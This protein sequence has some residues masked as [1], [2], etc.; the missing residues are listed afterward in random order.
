[1]EGWPIQ[2]PRLRPPPSS[3]PVV[4]TAP[5]HVPAVF[6]SRVLRLSATQLDT[7]E[8]CPLRYA[9]Q[10]AAG[11]RGDGSVSSELG[12][13]V[14]EVLAEFLSPAAS[15]ERD[16]AALQAVAEGHWRD[17]I[18][19]FRPQVEETRRAYFEMLDGWWDAEGSDAPDVLATEHEFEIAVG[20]HTVVGS[21]DRIDR[22]AGGVR[23]VDFKSGKREPAAKEMP[24]NLQLAVYHLAATRDPVIAAWGEPVA[25][26][27][28]F[29]RSMN[30]RSQEITADHAARTEARILAL[31]DRILAEEFVPSPRANCRY[32]DFHRLCPLQPEGREVGVA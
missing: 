4:R 9:Y 8:D 25:L 11:V 22:V 18:A 30:V 12:T 10:Y 21:I 13:L 17:D 19:R 16:R 14:H 6:P 15:H 23:I 31:A 28:V 2:A 32:C 24:D 3:P 1:V 29:L 5:T 27:L 20:P 26:D 7:Y